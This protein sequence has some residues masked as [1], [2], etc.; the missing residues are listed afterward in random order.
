MG[1]ASFY[2]MGTGFGQAPPTDI[3][4]AWTKPIGPVSSNE[5]GGFPGTAL[6][7]YPRLHS[8]GVIPAVPFTVNDLTSDAVAFERLREVAPLLQTHNQVLDFPRM[9]PARMKEDG[10]WSGN[11]DFT[12]AQAREHEYAGYPE[13]WRG[14]IPAFATLANGAH[15]FL[16]LG[17]PIVLPDGTRLPSAGRVTTELALYA[18]AAEQGQITHPAVESAAFRRAVLNTYRLAWLIAHLRAGHGDAIRTVTNTKNYGDVAWLYT[19]ESRPFP[20]L[21]PGWYTGHKATFVPGHNTTAD[22]RGLQAIL[23]QDLTALRA[24]M[25]ANVVPGSITPD[26]GMTPPVPGALAGGLMTT[27]MLGVAGYLIYQRFGG[28]LPKRLFKKSRGAASRA[29]TMPLL[30]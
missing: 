15:E 30:S 12:P 9:T 6:N 5:A 23:H 26:P 29:S 17:R 20:G 3:S 8:L 2:G 25:S 16:T 21:P 1:V 7:P 19:D 4:V 28:R 11:R 24:E 22:I 18:R 10:T 13:R 14:P 27:A